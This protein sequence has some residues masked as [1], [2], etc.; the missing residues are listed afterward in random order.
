M[1]KLR[2]REEN[3][4]TRGHTCTLPHLSPLSDSTGILRLWNPSARAPSATDSSGPW[5]E[6]SKC[7]LNPALLQP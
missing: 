2:P 6:I 1:K 7:L 3:S 4:I 5:N